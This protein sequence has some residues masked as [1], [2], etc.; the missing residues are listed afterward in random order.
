MRKK[1]KTGQKIYSLAI[2]TAVEAGSFALFRNGEPVDGI[3]GSGVV[4]RSADA[5]FEI[6]IFSRKTV[7]QQI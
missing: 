2:E 6:K 3:V 4:S 5:L 1:E 7:R